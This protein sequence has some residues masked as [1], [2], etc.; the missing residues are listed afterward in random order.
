MR[1]KIT[2]AVGG[3]LAVAAAAVGLGGHETRAEQKA[4]PAATPPATTQVTRQT[5]TETEKV[6]GTLGYGEQTV[7]SAHG[8]GM[9]TWLPAEGA[10]ITR[11]KAVYRMDNR[12]RPLL[13]GAIP[14]YE[15]LHPGVSGPDVALLE[16][17]LAA[18]GYTGFTVDDDYTGATADAVERWQDD[19]GLP[20]TGVIE[21]GQTTV[22]PGPIRVAE[23]K[24][25][26][27]DPASG[28]VLSFT[29]TTRTVTV[30]LAVS[31][32][33]LAREGAAAAVELP[34]GKDVAGVVGR[35]GEVAKGDADK[36]TIEVTVTVKNQKALGTLDQAPVTVTLQSEK[37]ENVLTVP[38]NALVA[39]PEGG[40]A[41]QLPDG[42]YRKVETGLFAAGRVEISGPG[43]AQ[44]LTVGVPR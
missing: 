25:H 2:V 42:S 40:Y 30:P 28:P 8:D 35:V 23:V 9:V 26:A 44:G 3:T 15:T 4:V 39:L 12:P 34:D 31:K 11:G 20:Q 7:L 1:G 43:V 14:I 18:L 6:D 32:Q 10:V 17:N 41:V 13:Y 33:Q 5:L 36:A 29:G 16:D 37:R 38:V 24:A 22:A 21:P 27:G 19:L